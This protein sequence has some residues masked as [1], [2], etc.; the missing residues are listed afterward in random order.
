M[1]SVSQEKT[2][3]VFSFFIIQG[4]CQIKAQAST[5]SVS[6]RFPYNTPRFLLL[7]VTPLQWWDE[8]GLV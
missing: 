1:L 3:A 7:D 6:R 8:F 2:H 5:G 4:N